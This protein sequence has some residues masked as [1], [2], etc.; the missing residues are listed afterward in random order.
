MIWFPLMCSHK[1]DHFCKKSWDFIKFSKGL[2]A[3]FD[4]QTIKLFSFEAC[5]VIILVNFSPLQLL[6]GL[7]LSDPYLSTI[8]HAIREILY[9]PFYL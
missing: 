3:S 8:L 4:I 2:P 6:S 7:A 1:K 9:H 5:H